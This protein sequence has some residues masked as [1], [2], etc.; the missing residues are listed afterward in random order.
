[1]EPDEQDGFAVHELIEE[2]RVRTAADIIAL[3]QAC[4]E[5]VKVLEENDAL[6]LIMPEVWR[7]TL[8]LR[9]LKETKICLWR[10]LKNVERMKPARVP[11]VPQ[12]SG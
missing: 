8:F 2:I 3:I 7:Q 9:A 4:R 10:A 1:M 6:V 11:K 12:K 5:M